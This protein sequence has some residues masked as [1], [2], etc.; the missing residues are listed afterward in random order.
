MLHSREEGADPNRNPN[1]LTSTLT[2][3]PLVQSLLVRDIRPRVAMKQ[4]LDMVVEEEAEC[5]YLKGLCPG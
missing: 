5:T 4:V 1:T 2:Q 3:V